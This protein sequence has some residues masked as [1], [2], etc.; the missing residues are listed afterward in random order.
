[1]ATRAPSGYGTGTYGSGAYG[2]SS[3]TEEIRVWS[4]DNFGETLLA[5]PSGYGLFQWQPEINYA[6]LAVTGDFAS[7]TGWATGTDWSIGSGV[8]TKTAGTGANLSSERRS[9]WP[10]VAGITASEFDASLSV[11]RFDQVSELTQ[12]RPRQSLTW[13]WPLPPS[14]TSGTY[15]PCLPHACRSV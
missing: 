14:L 13:P 6:E 11:G 2:T 3:S 8:A 1:V 4:L 9:T 12:A 10:R 15:Q 5:N 7:S